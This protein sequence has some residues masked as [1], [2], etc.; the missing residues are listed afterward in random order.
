MAFNHLAIHQ[1]LK[2]KRDV[3]KGFD[4]HCT[5]WHGHVQS[6]ENHVGILLG[7]INFVCS[8]HTYRLLS[9]RRDRWLLWH[10]NFSACLE[11]DYVRSRFTLHGRKPFCF[12]VHGCLCPTKIEK[13]SWFDVKNI[14]KLNWMELRSK[15]CQREHSNK[16]FLVGFAQMNVWK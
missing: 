11:V 4:L 7:S 9:S 3:Q 1:R 13:K 2:G 12:S 10:Q 14:S 5:L 16:R 15:K 8:P 6:V